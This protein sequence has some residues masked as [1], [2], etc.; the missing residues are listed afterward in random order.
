MK[1]MRSFLPALLLFLLVLS[2]F[3]VVAPRETR[4][5]ENFTSVGLAGSANV[6][7]RQG[8]PQKVE[9]EA[10]PADLAHFETVVSGGQLRVGPKRESN[11]TS[12]YRFKGPVTVYVTT[13]V[14]KSLSVSGSGNMRAADALKTDNLS[15][16]VSGSGDLELASVT[17]D[18]ISTSLAGSGSVQAAGNAPRHDISISG[19][20]EVRATKLHTTD[21]RVSISGSGDCR[22]QAT[23]NLSASIVGSGDVYVS[24][25]PK[26]S[27]STVGSGRVHRQ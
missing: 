2:A 18:K 17:A 11:F 27:T 13:P 3:R 8:S 9:V 19:S 5:V 6:I 25:N 15:L 14:I 26:I 1:T 12:S 7:L 20:G 4:P 24:G 10:D 23:Q 22:V 21:C 16:S